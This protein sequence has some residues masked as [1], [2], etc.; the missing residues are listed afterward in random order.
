[1]YVTRQLPLLTIVKAENQDKHL[2]LSESEVSLCF[3]NQKWLL[4]LFLAATVSLAQTHSH[5]VGKSQ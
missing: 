2:S 5:C 1:M 4:L 3:Q